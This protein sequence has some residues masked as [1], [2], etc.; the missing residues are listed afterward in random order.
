MS[1]AN[2]EFWNAGADLET[3]VR[4]VDNTIR[5]T[6][7]L[8]LI[9]VFVFVISNFL[10][11]L[12]LRRRIFIRLDKIRDG[13]QSFAENRDRLEA[14]ARGDEIGAISRSLAHYMDVIDERESQLAEKTNAL[15]QLSNQLAK[16]L[17]PQIY[18][19][20]FSGNK[21]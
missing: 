14:D 6:S 13:L 12:V 16:Y 11:W 19:S 1:S 21:R 5:I 9:V 8:I 4:R 7:L 3:Q 2:R 15:E 17:S 20:I 18:D 10:M